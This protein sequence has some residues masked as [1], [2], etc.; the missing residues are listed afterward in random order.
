MLQNLETCLAKWK[1]ALAP[2]HITKNSEKVTLNQADIE[3]DTKI[4]FDI[5]LLTTHY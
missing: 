2:L 1:I 5:F 4:R 3:A